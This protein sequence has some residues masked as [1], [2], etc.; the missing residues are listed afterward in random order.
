MRYIPL[1][2]PVHIAGKEVIVLRD[3]IGSEV[4]TASRDSE[5]YTTIEQPSLDGRP[6]IYIDEHELNQA[7]TD[8]P[9]LEVYGL[10]QILFYNDKVKLGSQIVLYPMGNDRGAYIRLNPAEDLDSPRSILSSA[11]YVENYIP[12]AM[13]YDL[14]DARRIDIEIDELKLPSQPAFTRMELNQKQKQI[15]KRRWFLVGI[16]CV[17]VA[18]GATV[19]NYSLNAVYKMQMASYTATKTTRTALEDRVVAL[20]SERLRA[21]PD[22]RQT[23]LTLLRLIERDPGMQTPSAAAISSGFSS[24][25]AWVSSPNLPYDPATIAPNV[26]ST[27]GIDFR[28]V[29]EV[30]PSDASEGGVN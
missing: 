8:Y 11:E 1:G 12:E 9:N 2:A 22:N 5:V 23:A 18:L 27:L 4:L 13:D 21:Y 19:L 10:W 15:E 20:E 14:N 17:G 30:T 29:I 3:A 26:T 28:Y 24:V 6:A 7:R 25:H 16:I